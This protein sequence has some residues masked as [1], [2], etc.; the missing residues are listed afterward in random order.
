MSTNPPLIPPLPPPAP[1]IVM[2]ITYTP[3]KPVNV[4]GPLEDRLLCYAMLEMARD[5]IYE[6]KG[7]YIQV[8]IP[9]QRPPQP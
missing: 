6:Y 4:N 5:A 9:A 8:P 7:S 2:T 3:G 1:T